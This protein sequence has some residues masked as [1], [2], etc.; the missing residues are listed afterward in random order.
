MSTVLLLKVSICITLSI[1][2]NDV[3]FQFS[4]LMLPTTVKFSQLKGTGFIPIISMI[5]MFVCDINI[6]LVQ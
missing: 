3:K 1:E 5:I 4:V 2:Y 6:G